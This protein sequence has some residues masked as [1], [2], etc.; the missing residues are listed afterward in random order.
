MNLSDKKIFYATEECKPVPLEYKFKLYD[1]VRTTKTGFIGRLGTVQLIFAGNEYSD[2][3]GKRLWT[4]ERACPDWQKKPVYTLSFE[5]GLKTIT[6]EELRYCFFKEHY[7]KSVAMTEK[8]IDKV[9]EDE[10]AILP[11]RPLVAYPEDGLELAPTVSATPEEIRKIDDEAFAGL[12][13]LNSHAENGVLK[14]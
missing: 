6:R 13:R 9:I 7:H 2:A 11:W 4:W 3:N 5:D 14:L 10:Y 1:R 12:V 8:E